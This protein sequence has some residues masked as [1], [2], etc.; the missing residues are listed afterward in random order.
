L[1]IAK[2]IAEALEAAHEQGIMELAAI[3]AVKDSRSR[4]ASPALSL[5]KIEVVCETRSLIAAAG[6]RARCRRARLML[7]RGWPERDCFSACRN[8]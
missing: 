1:P 7:T 2:Q 5:D 6:L 8:R 4:L 3:T